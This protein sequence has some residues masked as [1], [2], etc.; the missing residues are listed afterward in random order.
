MPGINDL[1]YDG[2]KIGF[3]ANLKLLESQMSS[4]QDYSKIPE[5]VFVIAEIGINHNGDVR[6]VL[7]VFENGVHFCSSKRKERTACWMSK[8]LSAL[9]RRVDRSRRPTAP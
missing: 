3:T 8:R 1:D 2:R 9:L 5:Q 6:N 7:A 4:I